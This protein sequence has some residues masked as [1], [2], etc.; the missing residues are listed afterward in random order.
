MVEDLNRIAPLLVEDFHIYS[1]SSTP[2]RLDFS[3]NKWVTTQLK[4]P[5]FL[6]YSLDQ[7]KMALNERKEPGKEIN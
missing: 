4:N 2:I 1:N 3:D 5:S 7:L 6:Q